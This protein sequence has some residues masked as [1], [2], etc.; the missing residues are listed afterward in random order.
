MVRHARSAIT[1]QLG[2]RLPWSGVSAVLEGSS[3]AGALTMVRRAHSVITKQS[4]GCAYQ[5]C[6]EALTMV[7][8]AI[9]KQSSGCGYHGQAC[10]PCQGEAVV[11]ACYAGLQEKGARALSA[12]SGPLAKTTTPPLHH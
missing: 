2:G 1:R 11:R 8:P 3:R 7:R 9:T 12:V 6:N 5:C 10:A 4:G